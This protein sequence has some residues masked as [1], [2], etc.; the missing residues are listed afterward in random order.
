LYLC[1]YASALADL[2]RFDEAMDACR[3]ALAV[4]PGF[5]QAYKS[6]G[7]YQAMLGNKSEAETWYRKALD[8]APESGSIWR[9]FSKVHRFTPDDPA[10]HE[11]KEWAGKN[12]RDQIPRVRSE[13]LFALSKAHDDLGEHEAAFELLA[14]SNALYRQGLGVNTEKVIHEYQHLAQ[15]FSRDNIIKGSGKGYAS[16]MPVFILGMPRSGTTLVEQI[17]ASHPEIHG[18][19]ELDFLSRAIGPGFMLGGVKCTASHN[20]TDNRPGVH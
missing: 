14:E 19:G 6:M 18:G 10:L 4:D 11:L 12:Q 3:K 8:A 17:L 16:D 7:N 20:D 2:G 1:N 15:I 5:A 13:F 9:H